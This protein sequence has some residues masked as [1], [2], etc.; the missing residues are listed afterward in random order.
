MVAT[1]VAKNGN[2]HVFVVGQARQ[3]VWLTFQPGDSNNWHGGEPGRRIAG[4]FRF[5]DAP[6]GR[7]IR[8]IA[9]ERAQNGNLHLF[10]TLDDG[11]TFYAWQA[12][13]S[14]AWSGAGQGPNDRSRAV[15]ELAA[16]RAGRPRARPGG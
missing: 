2:L 10:A 11:S 3:T 14:S 7:T 12:A 1:A 6:Q 9:A 13:N 4:L 5:A 16:G 8:G 15:D